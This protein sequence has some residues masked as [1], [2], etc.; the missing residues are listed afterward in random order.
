MIHKVS[1]FLKEDVSSSVLL[2]ICCLLFIFILPAL[3][4]HSD[5]YSIFLFAVI[6]LLAASVISKRAIMVGLGAVLIEVSTRATD[7]IYLHYL[8]EI[9]SNLFIIFIVA[10]VIRHLMKQKKVTVYSLIDAVN[11]YLLLGMMFIS[12]V[13]FCEVYIPGS[14]NASGNSEMEFIYYTMITLTTAGYGDITP[15]LPAAQSLAMFIAV[16]GQFYVAVIVAILVGK[17]ASVQS[18][19]E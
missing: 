19:S 14:Y 12:L 7:F 17:Y 10:S 1:V 13:A 8:A 9:T 18:A 11:G 15:K 6:M 2:L 3:E 4:M 16:T 5:V